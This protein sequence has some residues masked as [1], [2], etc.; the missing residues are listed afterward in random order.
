[1]CAL[2][3]DRVYPQYILIDRTATVDENRRS[4]IGKPKTERS[5]RQI[6]MSRELKETLEAQ[7]AKLESVNKYSS[8]GFVFPRT[9]GEM[10]TTPIIEEATRKIIAKINRKGEKIKP[11]SP[12]AWRA[13]FCTICADSGMPQLSLMQI[14]GHSNPAMTQRYYRQTTANDLLLMNQVSEY[15]DRMKALTESG[16]V[17]EFGR[18]AQ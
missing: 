4:V 1:M 18:K 15:R 11:F 3:W 17:V 16:D 2:T 14:L 5:F 12:H 8:T 6:P 10:A 9:N 13:T 7:R